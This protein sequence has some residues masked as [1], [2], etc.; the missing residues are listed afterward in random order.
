MKKMVN[1][2]KLLASI[3][4]C[5]IVLFAAIGVATS[6]AQPTLEDYV[7][8]RVYGTFI[9]AYFYDEETAESQNWE[10]VGSLTTT[11]I[12]V[13]QSVWFDYNQDGFVDLN[14]VYAQEN[15]QFKFLMNAYTLPVLTHDNA[16]YCM[17][18]LNQFVQVDQVVASIYLANNNDNA[19]LKD[20]SQ[21]YYDRDTHVLYLSPSLKEEL[22]DGVEI[23]AQTVAIVH[24]IDDFTKEFAL[25]TGFA[26]D[27]DSSDF[28]GSLPNGIQKRSYKRWMMDGL[29]IPLVSPS[30]LA[31]I[32]AKNLTVY[33]NQ[34]EY[35][36]WNYD[37]TTGVLSLPETQPFDVNNIVVCINAIEDVSSTDSILQ[38]A[39]YQWG[40]TAQAVTFNDVPVNTLC[41]HL[42]Y[43][44]EPKLGYTEPLDFYAFAF[45]DVA[46]TSGSGTFDINTLNVAGVTLFEHATGAVSALDIKTAIANAYGTQTVEWNGT[47]HITDLANDVL[48]LWN[49]KGQA[50]NAGQLFQKLNNM[51][52]NY[53]STGAPTTYLD[54]ITNE[55]QTMDTVSYG[56]TSGQLLKTWQYWDETIYSASSTI[57]MYVVGK[58][59][60]TNKLLEGVV[61]VGNPYFTVGSCNISSNIPYDP[62][63][64]ITKDDSH[65]TVI[66]IIGKSDKYL[67]V[68]IAPLALQEPGSNAYSR[69]CGFTRIRYTYT[70]RGSVTF[71]KTDVDNAWLGEAEYE[72]YRAN[73]SNSGALS[74]AQLVNYY[75]YFNDTD[76]ENKE[77]PTMRGNTI[78][79]SA[80]AAV[81]IALPYLSGNNETYYFKEKTPPVGYLRDTT[82]RYFSITANNPNTTVIAQD[83]KQ[84]AVITWQVLDATTR[85]TAASPRTEVGLSGIPFTLIDESGNP[86]VSY[87][88]QDQVVM[89]Y[90]RM[91]TDANGQIV[92]TVRP[93][94]YYVRQLDTIENY[95][96]D[97]RD[98]ED[99]TSIDENCNYYR[100]EISADTSGDHIYETHKHYEKRQEVRI[101]TQV[102]DSI[103]ENMTP[104]H[105]GGTGAGEVETVNSN[106]DLYVLQGNLLVGYKTTGEP[107]Y[108]NPSSGALNVTSRYRSGDPTISYAGGGINNPGTSSLLT[109]ISATHVIING[110]EYPLPNG[111][112]VWKLKQ[113]SKGYVTTENR[114]TDLDGKW[115]DENKQDKLKIVM[116]STDS[117]VLSYV[118]MDRQKADITIYSKAYDK[119]VTPG[120]FNYKNVLSSYKA[121]DWSAPYNIYAPINYDIIIDSSHPQVQNASIEKITYTGKSNAELY[122]KPFSTYTSDQTNGTADVIIG[123]KPHAVYQLH[124]LTDIVSMDGGVIPAN[125][126][127][128]RYVSDENGYIHIDTF[129]SGIIINPNV[130]SNDMQESFL[131]VT[132]IDRTGGSVN[133]SELP[134][135]D[136]LLTVISVPDEHEIEEMF[137]HT[138]IYH[139]WSEEGSKANLISSTHVVPF[140]HARNTTGADGNANTGAYIAASPIDKTPKDPYD[141]RN[142]DKPEED[143]TDASDI[144]YPDDIAWII[145]HRNDRAYRTIDMSNFEYTEDIIPTTF[146]LA[147]TD[148]TKT[149]WT[150]QYELCMYYEITEEEYNRAK[151]EFL[152]AGHTPTDWA[153]N[154]DHRTQA[155]SGERLYFRRFVLTGREGFSQLHQVISFNETTDAWHAHNS[156][157]PNATGSGAIDNTQWINTKMA[158]AEFYGNYHIAFGVLTIRE[159]IDPIS[160]LM[161][162]KEEMSDSLA[163]LSIRNR[164]LFNLD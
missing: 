65:K 1:N 75:D 92:F 88:A 94:V 64:N 98:K 27:V 56:D 153:R 19:E 128:G 90:D 35:E 137:E 82:L 4:V 48:S 2:K 123:G 130:T 103:I 41:Q 52:N 45:R 78:K 61:D 17:V 86:A 141:P 149:T 89:T 79:T 24:N 144:P 43:T 15:Y 154:W 5:A 10:V 136:Y 122:V 58:T 40:N 116:D 133:G 95:Y 148:S 85:N 70:G 113:A 115:I 63:P 102:Y 18:R 71:I 59:N 162:R 151:E 37:P 157:H 121:Y 34:K 11:D 111:S 50:V 73:K 150:T 12:I 30:H 97:M 147:H 39:Q 3:F 117:S 132:A 62:F 54:A 80:T 20:L 68:S 29:D 152:A 142:P 16:D 161:L 109:Y 139:P 57:G 21:Y 134:N 66:S 155:Y 125:S 46:T 9:P 112:Y 32:S 96:M 42:T 159:T 120:A 118:I 119:T 107:I 28:P 108:I 105:L 44:T 164:Q 49:P 143:P 22:I 101:Q 31:Y 67:L 146:A 6:M 106:W 72:I 131:N 77:N 47:T 7:N 158:A 38:Y 53:T 140:Y 81:K 8:N 129:G 104:P 33:V 26:D 127:L 100:I 93:G 25:V 36:D 51:Y 76:Y 156:I 126:I 23:K 99:L 83:Y 135:G 91:V 60:S 138:P 74:N 14:D 160:N 163:I 110:V 55:L 145:R 124:N 84:N 69:L 114:H 87:N 13:D